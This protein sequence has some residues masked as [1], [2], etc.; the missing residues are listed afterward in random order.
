VVPPPEPTPTLPAEEDVNAVARM[1][2]REQLSEPRVVKIAAAWVLKN[3]V[4]VVYLGR[5]TYRQQVETSE[6]AYLTEEEA[7]AL[8]GSSL[9]HFNQLL[10][11]ARGVINSSESNPMD[12]PDGGSSVPDAIFFANSSYADPGQQ[13]AYEVLLNDEKGYVGSGNW[14]YFEGVLGRFYFYRNSAGTSLPSSI[15]FPPTSTP[16]PAG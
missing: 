12:E 15:I 1:L 8:T 7:K 4:D 6:F 16:T 11:I 13:A 5:T 2:Y 14:G 3:R 10:E 9:E